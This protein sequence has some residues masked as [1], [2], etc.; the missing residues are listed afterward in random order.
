MMEGEAWYQSDHGLFLLNQR[1]AL[2][3]T[4]ERFTDIWTEIAHTDR[5]KPEIVDCRKLVEAA[6]ALRDLLLDLD[7][8]MS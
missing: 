7:K 4:S 2:A 5:D 1:P 3:I 8:L 6:L